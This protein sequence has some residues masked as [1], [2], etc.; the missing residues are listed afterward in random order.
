MIR[1]LKFAAFLCAFC[2][3]SG[4]GLAQN[5]NVVASVGYGFPSILRFALGQANIDT[6]TGYFRLQN[7]G[8]YGPVHGKSEYIFRNKVG[9]GA[10][11]VFNRLQVNYS[12]KFYD[13]FVLSVNERVYGARLN[14]YFINNA[15]T[16]F[17]CWHWLY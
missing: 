9:I 14:G 16:V 5:H 10:S 2:C 7:I 1:I 17:R 6:T 15:T 11:C 3:A 13:T 8:G 12:N 4:T